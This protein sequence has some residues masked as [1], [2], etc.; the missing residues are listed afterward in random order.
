M[1]AKKSK[2]ESN[3]LKDAQFWFT[4]GHII[5][6]HSKVTAEGGEIDH[7]PKESKKEN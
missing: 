7:M 4:K 3:I 6:T 5:Q 2:I 1:E